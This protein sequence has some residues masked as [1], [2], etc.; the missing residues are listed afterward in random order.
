M[1][2]NER[3]DF[4]VQHGLVTQEAFED[5]LN[6]L[7]TMRLEKV[8]QYGESRYEEKDEEI[9]RLM[10]FSDIHRKYIRLKQVLMAKEGGG[11][12][13]YDTLMDMASYALMGLQLLGLRKPVKSPYFIEQ[14]AICAKNPEKLKEA[15]KLIGVNEWA[16]DHVTTEGFVWDRLHR[17]E[18]NLNFN[19]QLGPFEFELLHYGR[20][21]DNWL[22]AQQSGLSHLGLHVPD[23]DEAVAPL[24][25]AGYT[26]AQDVKTIRHT[27]PAIKDSRR[28]R[29]VI[30][31]TVREFG[32][33][34]KLIQRL[35]VTS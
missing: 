16:E 33:Y 13:L 26:I 29:Y 34:L 19:Y 4:A 5:L 35:E 18:A 7:G 25:E 31:D 32:F 6:A 15:L 23:I 24:I 17:T 27:N 21:D 22:G 8:I 3:I 12:P 20:E 10:I 28:Y 30:M 9:N 2:A 1:Y 14:V 11:E